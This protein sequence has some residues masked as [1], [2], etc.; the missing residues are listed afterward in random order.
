MSVAL[1]AAPGTGGAQRIPTIGYLGSATGP[2]EVNLLSAF[3]DRLREL[4]YVEGRNV[5]VELRWAEGTHDRLLPL[6]N[7]LVAQK[8]DVIVAGA[9][10]ALEAQKATKTIPLVIIGVADPV[11]TGLAASL[12][13]PGGNATGLASSSPEMEQ[14]RLHIIRDVVPNASCVAVLFN[15]ANAH[16]AAAERHMQ[17][18][19]AALGVSLHSL[20]ARSASE[21]DTALD[22]MPKTQ[23]NASFVAADRLF[24]RNRG[25]IVQF[26]SR[27]RLAAMY[28]YREMVD[29]G[30]LM[31]FDASSTAMYRQAADYVD[32]IL[33]GAKPA[34]MPIGAPAGFDLALNVKTARAL[35]IAFPQALLSRA[36][37]VIQ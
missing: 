16:L 20:P 15:P 21:L 29:A 6:A 1:S 9:E 35:G 10:A 11:G 12:A 2:L 17:T 33:K 24:L 8:V 19:A 26:M 30:G 5:A 28:A 23:C 32:R 34:T 4:G 14:M 36:D 37:H 22:E 18:S 27:N 13:R 3:R 7:V 31:S 25:R